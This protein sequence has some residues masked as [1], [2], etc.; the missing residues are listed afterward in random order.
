M[1]KVKEPII[2]LLIKY[3]KYILLILIMV[4]AFFFMQNL[5]P[6]DNSLVIKS[7]QEQISEIQNNIFTID[8]GAG[9]V[10]TDK[11]L[12]SN[13]GDYY[14]LFFTIRATVNATTAEK[15]KIRLI[16]A[17]D[18]G[19]RQTLSDISVAQDGKIEAKDLTFKTN[20]SFSYFIIQRDDPNYDPIIKVGD[21]SLSRLNC[22]SDQCLSGL[23]STIF[24]NS[25]GTKVTSEMD[26][27]NDLLFKFGFGKAGV[28]QVFSAQSDNVSWVN[29]ALD[30]VGTGGLG[31]YQLT[32]KKASLNSGNLTIDPTVLASFQFDPSDLDKYSTKKN[33][34]RFPLAS[35]L[36]KG[37]YYFLAIDNFAVKTNYF[38]SIRIL[39]SCNNSSYPIAGAYIIGSNKTIGDLFF[40]IESAQPVIEN[41]SKIPYNAVI[42]DLGQ[43][44][45]LYRYK[46]SRS[47]NDYLDIFGNSS[48]SNQLPYLDYISDAVSAPA[49]GQASFSYKFDTLTAFDTFE[50]KYKQLGGYSVNTIGYYSFDDI[51]WKKIQP[52]DPAGGG[53][54]FGQSVVGDGKST[55]LYLKFTYDQEDIG[56]SNK[57]FGVSDLGIT[58]V[59]KQK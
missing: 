47:A 15:S 6:G 37:Q 40:Q 48:S 59:I 53:D 27:D 46:F 45:K 9:S 3:W 55:T 26:S 25:L 34:Y 20:G 41:G 52:Q 17:G 56:K 23:A 12:I 32:L 50:I 57:V 58:G 38:N 36:E 11:V 2:N 5:D 51:N 7:Y 8:S 4:F 24:G 22:Q 18:G 49:S 19:A 1:E 14:H 16:L 39:G 31:N 33:T 13:T 44:N 30:T 29:L 28:G 10:S 21:I 43:G 42:E 54:W 35:N